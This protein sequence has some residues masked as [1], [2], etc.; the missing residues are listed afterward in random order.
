MGQNQ[1]LPDA[2]NCG[3]AKGI[4]ASVSVVDDLD[5][6]RVRT[7]GHEVVT[8]ITENEDLRTL[9]FDPGT[10]PPAERAESNGKRIGKLYIME[11]SNPL[12]GPDS[13][14]FIESGAQ[15]PAPTRYQQ[16]R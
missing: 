4:Q 12:G 6:S 16:L 10:A 2:L 8:A 7:C 1:G 5:C 9:R 3:G 15:L 14:S 13:A 11:E